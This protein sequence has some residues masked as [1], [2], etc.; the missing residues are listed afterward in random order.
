MY[1]LV[2][3]CMNSLVERKKQ[4]QREAEERQVREADAEVPAGHRLMPDDER[5][6]TLD[7]IQLSMYTAHCM[8]C[9]TDAE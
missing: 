4:W 7:H 9:S 1:V 6:Q 3:V 2:H 8:P 5:L